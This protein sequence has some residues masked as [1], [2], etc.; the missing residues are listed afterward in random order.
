MLEKEY[1]QKDGLLARFL[2]LA[3][4]AGCQAYLSMQGYPSEKIPKKQK[5]LSYTL[6]RIFH[7]PTP[8]EPE[9]FHNIRIDSQTNLQEWYDF[10]EYCK[11]RELGARRPVFLRAWYRKLARTALRFAGI[12]HILEHSNS[13][14]EMISKNEIHRGIELASFYMY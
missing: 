6:E 11:Q 4:P 7:L 9:G 12:L 8:D 1:L 10:S 3:V 14:E 13:L 5:T 2:Y